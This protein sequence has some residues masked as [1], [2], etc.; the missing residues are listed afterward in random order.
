MK[1]PE[2]ALWM[3]GV[4]VYVVGLLFQALPTNT[5]PADYRAPGFVRALCLWPKPY[6][7]YSGVVLQLSAVA[8]FALW[9]PVR[10]HLI[11]PGVAEWLF[12]GLCGVSLI[13]YFI[14]PTR[15]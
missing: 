14:R 13:A 10:F 5:Q 3:Y 1:D 7:S 12:Y 15:R 4:C 6:L 11:S 8:A 9:L 2:G